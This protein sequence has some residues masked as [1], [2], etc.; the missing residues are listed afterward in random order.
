MANMS[1]EEALAF[2][3]KK[4][5][6]VDDSS[7]KLSRDDTNEFYDLNGIPKET[8]KAFSDATNALLVG[9]YQFNAK[10]TEE[11]AAQAK[12]DGKS[13]DEV[14]VKLSINS[15][16]FPI[17]QVMYAQKQYRNPQ[18][19]GAPIVKNLVAKTTISTTAI[20]NKSVVE[21]AEADFKKALG[22]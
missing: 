21:A 1:N 2:I 4:A 5:T 20:L 8:V 19:N 12:K 22:L 13:I 17:K 11:L 14:Q 7:Y 6:K 10:K 15:N 18:E 9:A 3:E 16:Q